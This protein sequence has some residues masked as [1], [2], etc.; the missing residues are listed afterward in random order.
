MKSEAN[1]LA[2]GCDQLRSI[3]AEQ[4]NIAVLLSDAG[5]GPK[6]HDPH[7][8]LVSRVARAVTEHFLEHNSEAE[9]WVFRILHELST[10]PELGFCASG[11]ADLIREGS[12]K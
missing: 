1:E 11:V 9:P 3:F 7:I 10:D 8:Y 12:S 5:K 4:I 2:E 6:I